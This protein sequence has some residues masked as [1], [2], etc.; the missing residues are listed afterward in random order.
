MPHLPHPGRAAGLLA[1]SLALAVAAQAQVPAPFV[2]TWKATWAT[3]RKSYEAVM[4]VT[5]SGGTWQT[6]TRGESN[7]C[8][9]REVPLKVEAA[10]ATEL[11]LQLQFSE[12]IP[13][14]QNVSVT[15]KAGPDG[16]VTGTRNKYELT[17]TRK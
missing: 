8:A 17:L 15:L 11:K 7:P 13:G 12:V 1:A 5:D 16:A 2:G 4:T 10:A 9:G 3:E 14:C 6:A